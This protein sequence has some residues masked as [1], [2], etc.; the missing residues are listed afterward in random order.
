MAVRKTFQ[1]KTISLYRLFL[2]YLAAF[3]LATVLLV[4]VLAVCVSVGFQRGIV[5]PANH[6]ERAVAEARDRIARSEPFDR[7]LI[8]FPCTYILMDENGTV[9]ESDMTPGEIARARKRLGA[10]VSST[11]H[12][13]AL[14]QREDSVCIVCYDLYAHFASPVLHRWIPNP[15]VMILVLFLAL[16][17]LDAS[18]TAVCF[19]RR[20]RRELEPI[21]RTVEQIAERELDLDL[22]GMTTGILELNTVLSSIQDM[23]AALE[24]SLK[25]QWE[26]EQNRRVQTSAVAHDI[27]I[28]L[29]IVRGNAELLLEEEIYGGDSEGGKLLEGIRDSAGRIEKY[30][31][32]LS[33]AAR[34][35]CAELTV[36]GNF[37]VEACVREI[38]Q[39]AV[40]LCRPKEI[41][42]TVRKEGLPETFYGDR[43]LII[44]A[45]SNIL[46]NA[47][48]YTP[49]QGAVGLFI[50]G[51]DGQLVFRV[52]DSGKGFSDTS[53]KY[54]VRQFYTE[55]EARS[56]KH[57]GLG[58]F[59]AD[60]AAKRHGGTLVAANR[61]DGNGAVVTL[62]VAPGSEAGL[63]KDQNM[64]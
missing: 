24:Q 15:E 25:A 44:R 46:D 43:E 52:T 9:V 16:F 28:P 6:A 38:E 53:L 30:I 37:S 33:D 22:D 29:T 4:G 34:A 14:I 1:Q 7:A 45:V 21:V 60:M 61:P 56:G 36:A 40:S 5:L 18:V 10:L 13:Y 47:A 49:G 48:E 41:G 31:G 59:I 63:V 3:C 26:A 11:S 23:G 27:K 20:L 39:Q 58:L 12:R 2:R 54:A 57:Y 32:L 42:L 64:S 62:T 51:G 8:P 35:E 50:G 17:L 55:C 19:G